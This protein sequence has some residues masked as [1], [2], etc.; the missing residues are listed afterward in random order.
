MGLLHLLALVSEEK[1]LFEEMYTISNDDEQNYPLAIS[2]F[3]FSMK[4]M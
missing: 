3:E 4:S 1:G 2:L